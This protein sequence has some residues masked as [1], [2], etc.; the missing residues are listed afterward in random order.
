MEEAL[1]RASLIRRRNG[2][3]LSALE[4]QIKQCFLLRRAN[5]LDGC[6][7]RNVSQLLRDTD[8][9]LEAAKIIDKADFPGV[10]A[11]PNA[12][13]GNFFDFSE[14]QFPAFGDAVCEIRIDI[15]KHLLND[16]LLRGREVPLVGI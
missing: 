8:G 16:L 3:V 11:A 1:N 13:P 2:L 5:D 12:A 4:K 15:L 6:A 10:L 14:L 7:R 9:T